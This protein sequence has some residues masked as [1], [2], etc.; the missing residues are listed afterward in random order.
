M[1]QRSGSLSVSSLEV[2]RGQQ[3]WNE[4]EFKII[5]CPPEDGDQETKANFKPSVLTFRIILPE[6][7]M[8]KIASSVQA[9]SEASVPGEAGP[10]AEEIYK[11]LET[12]TV[13]IR[14]VI[15]SCQMTVAECTRLEINDVIQLPGI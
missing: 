4:I 14:A 3:F 11:S 8:V 7:V 5:S 2:P 10:W 1:I 9:T 6:T 12:A 13:P 15:E